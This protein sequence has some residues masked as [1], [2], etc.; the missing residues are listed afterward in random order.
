VRC[1]R[2]IGT[3]SITVGLVFPGTLHTADASSLSY[4][5][6]TTRVWVLDLAR[7]E[8]VDSI[9]IEQPGPIAVGAGGTVLY[10]GS[11]REREP[12]QVF[13]IST[14]DGTAVPLASLPG[15]PRHLALS[16]DGRRLWV[17]YWKG[18]PMGGACAGRSGVAAVDVRTGKVVATFDQAEQGIVGPNGIVVAPNGE[19]VYFTDVSTSSVGIIDARAFTLLDPVSS[20][21]C[22]E[23]AI[24]VSPD[25]GSVHALGN[26]FGGFIVTIDART[27]TVRQ[28][29]F[30]IG[31]DP[32]RI[33]FEYDV[34]IGADNVTAYLA[35]SVCNEGV[36]EG[37]MLFFDT[38][39]SVLERSLP[40]AAVATRIAVTAGDR[41][42]LLA[43]PAAESVAVVNLA[44]RS[45][46]G[47]HQAHEAVYDVAASRACVGDCN[48]S[49]RCADR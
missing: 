12:F 2:I 45:V 41:F 11:R 34:E 8:V 29:A 32:E 33:D 36:C 42:A 10:V 3:L 35:G 31:Q 16:P 28:G 47:P 37:A 20:F 49:G 7:K 25:G 17:A 15:V 38:V 18:C 6:G 4:A 5:T 13:V 27:D 48:G 9:P 46:V 30:L 44:S 21:C 39:R 40:V 26:E 22:L 24:A 43:L 23:S 14:N 1:I 19:K